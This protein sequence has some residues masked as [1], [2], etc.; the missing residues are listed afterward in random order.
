VAEED[1][2]G[3]MGMDQDVAGLFNCGFFATKLGLVIWAVF[4]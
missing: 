1:P 4:V 2:I 3:S